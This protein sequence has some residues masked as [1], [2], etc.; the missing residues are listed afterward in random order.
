MSEKLEVDFCEQCEK[1]FVGVDGSTKWCPYC[2]AKHEGET[3][4]ITFTKFREALAKQT[5]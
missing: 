2:G 1:R 5:N 4:M 3:E